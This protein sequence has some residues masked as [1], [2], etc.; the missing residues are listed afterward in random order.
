MN[1]V[2]T[3]LLSLIYIKN[4]ES[5][6]N[7]FMAALKKKRKKEGSEEKIQQSRYKK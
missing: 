6:K 7:N 4:M 5:L 2:L 3:R 1:I